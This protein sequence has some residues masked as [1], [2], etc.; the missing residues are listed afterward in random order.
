M[1]IANVVLNDFTR[2]NRV[3]KISSSLVNDGHEVTVVALHKRDYLNMKIMPRVSM[4][5]VFR[6]RFLPC[7]PVDL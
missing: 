2:D 3:L 7:F 5:V 6:P 1:R 4:C